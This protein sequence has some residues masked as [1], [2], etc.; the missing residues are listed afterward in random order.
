MS[1]LSCCDSAISGP[2]E[3][4]RDESMYS[5]MYSAAAGTLDNEVGEAAASDAAAENSAALTVFDGR[6]CL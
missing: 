3:Y 6:Y 1:L 4:A 5:P 2:A